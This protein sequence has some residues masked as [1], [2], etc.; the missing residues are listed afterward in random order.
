MATTA[1]PIIELL[2]GRD[3]DSWRLYTHGWVPPYVKGKLDLHGEAFP[4][5][6]PD[7]QGLENFMFQLDAPYTKRVT[8]SGSV[9]IEARG[10]SAIVL[11][12]WL[13]GFLSSAGK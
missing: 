6:E 11:G 13:D 2:I 1:Q 5:D 3:Q 7:L 10:R 12:E 8:E 9:E 4:V